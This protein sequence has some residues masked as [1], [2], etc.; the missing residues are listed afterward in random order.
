MSLVIGGCDSADSERDSASDAQA[1]VSVDSSS[2]SDQ[3]AAEE[4]E[5]VG[6][7]NESAA[8]SC[9][10]YDDTFSAIQDAIFKRHGCTNDDCH[11]SKA[12]GGLDLRPE[13]A[14]ETLL[15]VKAKASD[16]SR[17][18]PGLPKSSFLYQKL[19]A[20]TAPGSVQV[21]GSP[22]PIGAQPLSDK[23][24]AAVRIWISAGAP[25][26]GSVGDSSHLGSSEYVGNLLGA[27]LPPA[28]PVTIAEL[29]PPEP[30]EG[31]QLEMPVFTLPASTELEICF[32]SYYDLSEQ[33]PDRFKSDDGRAF[34]I[35]G[36]TLRQDANSHHMIMTN[37]GIDASRVDDPAF[38]KWLCYGGD[39]DGKDCDPIDVSSCG[40]GAHCG[41]ELKHQVTC[42]GFGPVDDV[43]DGFVGGGAGSIVGSQ[44]A[45][46]VEEPREGVYRTIP[47]K[48]FIYFNAHAFNLTDKDHPMH[49][50]VNLHY[51]DDRR[52]KRISEADTKKVSAPAGI[53]PFEKST[54]CTTHVM[55]KGSEL[56]SLGSHTHKRGERFWVEDPEGKQIYESLVYSDPVYAAFEPPLAFDAPDEAKRT[57]KFCATFNNGV[58][59]DGLPDVSMVTRASTMPDRTECKPVACA[60]GKVGASCAGVDDNA[61]CDSRQGAGDGL[62]DACTITAG[63]TTEN[64]MFVLMPTYIQR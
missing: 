64:E 27:C 32:A 5:S 58:T 42:N 37:P 2:S 13:V 35:N 7:A 22:M 15:D 51:T 24:L 16:L 18:V 21:A 33:V 54:V 10:K 45:Q 60:A 55:P 6:G 12:S 4:S 28:E 49:A 30:E 14:Y 47:I 40:A 19:Q 53:P 31:A 41:T 8:D 36:L 50:R 20:A 29:A 56:I 61:V 63:P 34:T 48:G 52:F 62:C 3:R 46:Y 57:L 25:K 1:H 43:A 38:G 17:I 44:T 26:K 9:V 11:G 59:A 23:E 39:R